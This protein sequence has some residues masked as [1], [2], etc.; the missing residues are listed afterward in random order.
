MNLILLEA[1]EISA[2][3]PRADPRAVHL[4]GVLRRKAGDQFV[5]EGQ[6]SQ[7][8]RVAG[9]DLGGDHDVAGFQ[10]RIQPASNAEAD[11]APER[12][13]VEGRKQRPQLPG[14]ATAAD[15]GHART[16]GNA[17]LLHQTGH[18]KYW[19]RVHPTARG[20]GVPRPQ[21]HI[22]TPTTLLLVI[23]RFRYRASAQSGKNFA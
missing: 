7:P 14:I 15:H 10:G 17:R 23:F 16:G 19:P 4:V 12:D 13:R 5:I 9:H 22:P 6:T 20:N 21:I 8:A 3:L 2:P 1:S 11:D 18:N